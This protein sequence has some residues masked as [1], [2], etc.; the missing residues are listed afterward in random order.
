MSGIASTRSDTL[1]MLLVG[2]GA[3]FRGMIAIAM[4]VTVIVAI[5]GETHGCLVGDHFVAHGAEVNTA[6]LGVGL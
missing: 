3:R 2:S 4:G 5:C 6:C 1:L